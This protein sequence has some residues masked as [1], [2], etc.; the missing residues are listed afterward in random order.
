MRQQQLSQ[1]QQFQQL[2]MKHM[3]A[4]GAT[5]AA[6]TTRAPLQE[7]LQQPQQGS[8]EQPLEQPLQEPLLEL[9]GDDELDE[10]ALAQCVDDASSILAARQEQATT[11][12]AAL[13]AQAAALKAT[14]M[15]RRDEMQKAAIA[16][17]AK[18]AREDADKRDKTPSATNIVSAQDPR[19]W[20]ATGPHKQNWN[21]QK[22]WEE[23]AWKK[24][25]PAASPS[26]S[27]IYRGT[28][29]GPIAIQHSKACQGG[30]LKGIQI[31]RS[32]KNA[33]RR[34]VKCGNEGAGCQFHQWLGPPMNANSRKVMQSQCS[35]EEPQF[36]TCA[37][38]SQQKSMS[39]E[40]NAGRG[41]CKGCNQQ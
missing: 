35:M 12:A 39:Q 10:D 30:R 31:S 8:L 9:I 25:K 15:K 13:K 3:V 6:A 1:Q 16:I 40:D 5:T 18:R 22:A 26:V 21:R 17:R 27:Q 34:F 28:D 11:E 14:Q 23:P 41:V 32:Q 29:A 20:C 38:C 37:V 4:T 33:G 2:Q 7:T 36:F 19:A 24:C